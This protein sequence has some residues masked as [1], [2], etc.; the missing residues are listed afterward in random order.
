ME[1]RCSQHLGFVKVG[2]EFAALGM[3]KARHSGD[4]LILK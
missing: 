4:L 3:M 1:G 2:F